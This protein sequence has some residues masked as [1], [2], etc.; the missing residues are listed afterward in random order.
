MQADDN[1]LALL[2]Q[3]QHHGAEFLFYST[4]D[5]IKSKNSAVCLQRLNICDILCAKRYLYTNQFQLFFL[6]S[7]RSIPLQL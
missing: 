4:K 1:Y 6:Y 5:M 3:L 7:S 2:F